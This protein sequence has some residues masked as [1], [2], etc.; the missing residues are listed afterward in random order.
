MK[1]KEL[2]FGII[3]I[4]MCLIFLSKRGEMKEVEF[5]VGADDPAATEE[6]RRYMKRAC[7]LASSAIEHGNHPF[8]ALLVRDGEILL[9]F[10]NQVITSGDVTQHAETGLIGLATRKID[11]ETLSQSTLYA[12]TEPCIMCCGAIYWA[13]VTKI[14]FGTSA[15]EM[16]TKVLKREYQG[17]PSREIYARIGPH[18]E[19]IGPLDQER[20]LEIHKEGWPKVFK[21]RSE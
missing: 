17:I 5:K 7:E 4:S 2:S 19:I 14:V 18:V 10:E 3:V 9:E 21:A 15:R 6:D 20:G 13:G 11:R 8:G 16:V 12:S 1:R